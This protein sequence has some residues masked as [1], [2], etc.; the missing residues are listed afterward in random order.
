M[1]RQEL[2]QDWYV[3]YRLI[4]NKRYTIKQKDRF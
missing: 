2:L 1:N 4:F 3:R